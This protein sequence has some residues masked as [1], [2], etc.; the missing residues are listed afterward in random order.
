VTLAQ[1]IE[2]FDRRVDVTVNTTE[3]QELDCK[4]S[5]TKTIKA[6]PNVCELT[7]WNLSAEHQAQ[8]E[9][10]RPTTTGAKT[11]KTSGTKAVSS[12]TKLSKVQGKATTGIPC[13][14]EAGYAAGTSLVWLGDLR[15]VQTLRDGPE[16]VTTL[17]SGDG[18]RAWVNARQHV[19]YGPGTPIATALRAMVKALGIPEGNLSKVVNDLT[20]SGSS[21]Y[22]TGKSF[23]GA[24]SHQLADFARSAGLEV[25]VQDGA[26]QFQNR[27][28]ADNNAALLVDADHGMIDSPAVDNNGLLSVRVL[29]IP[30]VKVGSLITLDAARI[31][32]TYRIQKA[33]WLGDTS[34]TDW[35]IDLEGKRY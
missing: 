15:S 10:I 30:G 34:S 26:L 32:G 2:L 35:Y 19:S 27:G 18:E 24:V 14:I 16:W 7:I 31:K 1:S 23:T 13:R 11:S 3:F 4:F 12:P 29:M 25:S 9:E 33:T 5:I 20:I 8:L 21:L 28:V 17:T 22:P 6:E